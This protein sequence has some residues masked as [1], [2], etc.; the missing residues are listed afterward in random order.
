[1]IDIA[2]YS[3][4]ALVLIALLGAIILPLIQ[5]FGQP[6]S[7][8]KVGGGFLIIAVIFVISWA[9][10]GDEVTQIYTNFGVNSSV[11]KL[12]GGSLIMVYI[13]MA[14]LVVGLIYSEISK[15]FN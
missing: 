9:I 8:L 12:V 15:L 6:K 2:L 10:S 7:L 1:M 5:A 11:S 13:L 3:S 4:Y 14:T